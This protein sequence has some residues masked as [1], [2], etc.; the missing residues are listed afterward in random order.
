MFNVF[1]FALS[2]LKYFAQVACLIL[3]DQMKYYFPY[4]QFLNFPCLFPQHYVQS[5]TQSSLSFFYPLFL[6]P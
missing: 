1:T 5:H 3:E 6:P 2:C 4:S